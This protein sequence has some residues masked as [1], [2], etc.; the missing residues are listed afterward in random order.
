MLSVVDLEKLDIPP[1]LDETK[2]LYDNSILTVK[3]V[4]AEL[5]LE[6]PAA[7]TCSTWAA[8][9]AGSP[10]TSRPRLAARSRATTSTRTRSRTPTTGPERCDMTDRL[11][12]KV[13]NHHDPLDYE[14]EVR[15]EISAHRPR[16]LVDRYF[17]VFPAAT[18][19]AGV[20][21]YIEKSEQKR[22]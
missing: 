22:G 7:R 13:D 5:A 10:A 15:E 1:M 17:D 9:A 20:R 14:E 18:D 16:E 19:W 11:H 8:G 3:A 12:F 2:G 4:L 21:R 6:D